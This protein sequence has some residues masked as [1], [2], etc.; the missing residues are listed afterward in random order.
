M[1]SSLGGVLKN[2]GSLFVKYGQ[3]YGIDPALLA[4]I[5]MHETGNGT[6]SAARNKNNLGGMMDPSTNWSTLMTFDSLDAGIE[7]MARNL[8]K[9]YFDQGLN[10]ISAIAGKYAPVGADNDPNG[11][12]KYWTN[13]VTK[14]YNS[15]SGKG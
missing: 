9:N 7:A 1:N 12:N 14:F 8:K 13:G 10:S 5:S 3:K 2:S 11:L 4:A 15:L 6:S